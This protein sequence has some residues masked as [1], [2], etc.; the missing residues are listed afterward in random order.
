[1]K[2]ST[3]LSTAIAA[4]HPFI[5]V[6]TDEV[7]DAVRCLAQISDR[8]GYSVAIFDKL[9]GLRELGKEMDFST[10]QPHQMLAA[11][12]SF[13]GEAKKV[14]DD[15]AV[16]SA[17]MT[18]DDLN[19]PESPQHQGDVKILVLRNFHLLLGAK[20]AEE[21]AS[22]VQY[23]CDYGKSASYFLMGIVAPGTD[24]GPELEPLAHRITQDLPDKAE[25]TTILR[26]AF[27]VELGEEDEKRAVDA[28][29]GLT[30]YQAEKAFA[31]ARVAAMRD[32]Q[33]GLDPVLVWKTKAKVL[34]RE[35]LVELYEGGETFDDVGGLEGAK[36]FLMRIL[37]RQMTLD[38]PNCRAKGVAF[39]GPPGT[40]KSLVAKA[41]GGELGLPVLLAN[42]GNL[43]GGIVG[44]TER[45]TRR[46]FRICRSMAPCVVIVDEVS[47]VMPSGGGD[48]D[49]GV[50]ARM[51]GT[52]LT[53]MNDITEPIFW[54][55]TENSVESMHEAFLRAERVDAIFYVRLPSAAQRADIW[56]LYI[57][58]FFPEERVGLSGLLDRLKK[59]SAITQAWVTQAVLC[60]PDRQAALDA[61]HAVRPDALN[62]PDTLLFD[63]RG[64]TP[65]EIR[66]C[67]RIAKLLGDSLSLASA[68]IR[69]VFRT[70]EAQILRLNEWAQ[71]AALDCETGMNFDPAKVPEEFDFMSY[72]KKFTQKAAP[73]VRR[74]QLTNHRD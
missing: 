63:D 14:S 49:G 34:N 36:S 41:L 6:D 26:E 31:E 18:Q 7:N 60:E 46:F 62:A 40:G 38:D 17:G 37:Q 21:V 5:V 56:Q 13:L 11:I 69:P 19:S 73:Q 16:D 68:R 52:F 25:L 9:L 20:V 55:F 70:A 24:L 12:K 43:M 28:A 1:M 23:F 44:D 58:K 8:R 22:A 29:R 3:E 51:L 72:A 54:A 66:S 2:L 74:R 48:R 10:I 57:E 45:N 35:G 27:D 50:G 71:Q 47:K 39:C 59:N 32:K 61:I 4:C 65:A 33:A 42:P 67:C 15:K 64:W 30:R 53:Q